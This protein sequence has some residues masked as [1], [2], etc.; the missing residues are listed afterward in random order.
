MEAECSRLGVSAA[1][2]LR[3]AALAR[4]AFTAGRRGSPDFEAALVASGAAP[5]T[6]AAA[7][8][9]EAVVRP[10][11]TATP[12][13]ADRTHETFESSSENRLAA[14]ALG[15]QNELVVRRAREIR[16]QAQRLRRAVVHA[17]GG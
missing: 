7:Q 17:R 14:R 1:Q 4:L 16:V 9:G 11:G 3:E 13:A 6:Q 2:Y 8:P 5:L 15:A 10:F 12:T